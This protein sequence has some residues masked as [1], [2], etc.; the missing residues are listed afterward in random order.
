MSKWICWLGG[1]AVYQPHEFKEF[2]IFFKN[3]GYKI[4][5][6]TGS[7][8]D[9][10]FDLLDNVDVVIDGP[11]KEELGPVTKQTSNQKV[12]YKEDKQWKRTTF[13]NLKFLLKG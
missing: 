13:Q 12:W 11:W 2:N 5:L 1:D 6:Y 3:R 8:I 7:Y 9:D 10:I 4:C